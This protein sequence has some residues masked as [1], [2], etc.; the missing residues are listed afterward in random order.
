[1]ANKKKEDGCDYI[2]E[3]KKLKSDGPQ[4]LYLLR[5][6]E[7]YLRESFLDTLKKT[8]LPDGDDGFSYK[9]FDGPEIDPVDFSS[10]VDLMPF[11]SDRTMIELRDIDFNKCEEADELC[12]IISNIPEYCTVV[13]VIPAGYETDGRLKL[14]RAIKKAGC[15]L[16]F[17]A[18][19]QTLLF[20]WIDKRFAA[21]GKKIGSKEKM[22]L[23]SISGDLMNRLIPE[24]DKI[25]AY[26][27]GEEVQISDIDAVA[28]K[29]PEAQAFDMINLIGE[30]KY[31]D[32]FAVLTELVKSSDNSPVAMIS[33]LGYQLRRTF[34]TKLMLCSECGKRDIM[35]FFN[36]RYDFVYDNMVVS[37]KKFSF[38]S[39]I[40]GIEACVSAELR[41]KSS[42]SDDN[43]VFRDAMLSLMTGIKYGETAN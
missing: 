14:I 1:M 31:D 39:L 34:G 10:A 38:D 36:I 22:R 30:K 16:I 27:Y 4:R 24:I 15:E 11:L 25:S 13:F 32:A 5:G 6:S 3:I 28:D 19:P 37:A 26:T 35:D 7:D 20:N 9:R 12:N 43:E 23:V 42:S 29:I 41:M 17:E 33:A 8:V 18:Q 21:R 2:A 40:N